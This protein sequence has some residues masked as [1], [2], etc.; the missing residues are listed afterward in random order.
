MGDLD[1]LVEPESRGDPQCPLRWT[2]KSTGNLADALQTAGHAVSPDTVGRLL[3]Q[4]GYSLQATR[5][6]REGT[7]HPDR[8]AQLVYLSQRVAEHLR[9]GDPVISV[10][11]KKNPLRGGIRGLRTWPDSNFLHARCDGIEGRRLTLGDRRRPLRQ[12]S[13]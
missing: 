13:Q 2:A 6:T 1:A 3:K 7:R 9:A 8:D 4:L 11:S 12:P 10:D 5:K